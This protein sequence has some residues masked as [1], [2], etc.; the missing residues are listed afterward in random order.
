LRSCAQRPEAIFH[1]SSTVIIGK[2]LAT[3]RHETMP[4]RAAFHMA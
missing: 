3:L 1:F 2:N 4:L